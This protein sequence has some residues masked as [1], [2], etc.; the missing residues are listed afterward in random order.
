MSL[1]VDTCIQF[2][3]FHTVVNSSGSSLHSESFLS[4]EF[5]GLRFLV[6][7]LPLAIAFRH[8]VLVFGIHFICFKGF[9]VIG[10]HLVL[11][12]VVGSAALHRYIQRL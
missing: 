4:I 6:R 2:L 9:A 10:F 8:S 3:M 12:S 5:H 11:H 7:I 1:S